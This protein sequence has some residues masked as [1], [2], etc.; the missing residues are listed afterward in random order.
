MYAVTG[1]SFTVEKDEDESEEEETTGA[2]SDW[3]VEEE[4]GMNVNAAVS[5]EDEVTGAWSG[6]TGEG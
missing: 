5:K 1:Q 3:I 2:W 6:W 4:G